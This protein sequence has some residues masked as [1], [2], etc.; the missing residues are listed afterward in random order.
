MLTEWLNAFKFCIFTLI[1]CVFEECYDQ[2]RQKLSFIH[3]SFYS[4][5]HVHFTKLTEFLWLIKSRHCDKY[6]EYG[7]NVKIHIF[8]NAIEVPTPSHVLVCLS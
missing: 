1:Q 4:S 8:N 6:G 7:I 3:F 5:I 2:V